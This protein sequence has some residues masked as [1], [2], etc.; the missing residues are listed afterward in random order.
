MR[1][2]LFISWLVFLCAFAP[3]RGP[4]FGQAPDATRVELHIKQLGSK[5]FHEREAAA[6][7]L[8]RLGRVAL[9]ALR[10]ASTKAADPEV[11]RRAAKLLE[12]IAGKGTVGAIAAIKESKLSRRA[13]GRK[14]CAFLAP[15]TERSRV[16]EW[17]GPPASYL[18]FDFSTDEFYPDYDLTVNYDRDGVVQSVTHGGAN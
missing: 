7:E 5:K 10:Q 18:C 17:L 4:V 15:G 9:P 12:A 1:K 3:L 11:R 6:R 13:K 8:Q 2:R 16:Y 14:L